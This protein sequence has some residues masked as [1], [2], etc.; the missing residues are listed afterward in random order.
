MSR[1]YVAIAVA[2]ST[3]TMLGAA[4][5]ASSR[6]SPQ[7]EGGQPR[8]VNGRV[9]AQAAGSLAQTFK[10]LVAAQP[11]I[12]WIGYAV[13]VDDRDRTMC[14]FSSADGTTWVSGTS[15]SSMQCCGAC[16]I[17]PAADVAAA[18]E[19]GAAEADDTS[20]V[21]ETRRLGTSGDPVPDR[22]SES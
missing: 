19:T 1:R 15:S 11:E 13:P 10:S 5:A 9:N 8:I 21:G 18:V 17:E 4:T 6:R 3:C 14:C 22:R 20:R 7:G 2:L 16:R 12:A